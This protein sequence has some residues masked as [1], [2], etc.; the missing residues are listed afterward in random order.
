[1]SESVCL[2]A[3]QLP[4]EIASDLL[5][6]LIGVSVCPSS[7]E[8]ISEQIGQTF[9]AQEQQ[10]AQKPASEIAHK[11]LAAHEELPQRVYAQM[12]GA[13]INTLEGWK[14]N[15]LGIIFNENDLH[16]SGTGE[17]ERI[18]IKKKTLITSLAQG[19]D[20]FKERFKHWMVQTRAQWAR[21]IIFITDGAIWID[22]FISENY[23]GCIH[24]LDWFHLTEHLWST[25]KEIYGENS[26]KARLWVEQYKDLFY[27]GKEK[28]ALARILRA[29]KSVRKKQTPLFNLYNYLN[30]RR[31]KIRYKYFRSKGYYLGSGAVESANRYAIQDRLKKAGMKWSIDGANA[32]AFLRTQYLSDNWENFEWAA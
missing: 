28:E 12:D 13:M 7:I 27:N 22:H 3:S 25:A 9:R 1:M 31:D 23:Q 4:F 2:L 17:N 26:P 16:K 11:V 14:E 21:E 6:R 32:I 19:L 30:S 18:S 5:F 10:A 29:A 20:D 15:K 24:I 8:K